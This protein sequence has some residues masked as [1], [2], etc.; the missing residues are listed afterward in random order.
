MFFKG[1][2]SRSKAALV[3]NRQVLKSIAALFGSSMTSSLLS[4]VGGFLI[5]RFIGPG[6]TGQFRAFTIPLT[7][8]TFLHLGTFDG[9]WRQIPFYIGKEQ[10]D[11]VSVLAS[12]AGAWNRLISI[13]ISCGF[14]G[15]AFFCWWHN[16]L[17]GF[18]GWLTQACV[19]WQVFYGGY[20]SATYR[21]INQFTFLARIQLIQ[22]LFNFSLV[23]ITPFLAFYGLCLRA[24]G[25]SAI[26]VWLCQRQR[27]MRM[28]LKFDKPACKELLT[29]GLPFSILGSLYTSIWVASENALI[30]ALSGTTALGLFSVAIVLREGMNMLPQTVQQ[31]FLPRVVERYS[32]TGGVHAGQKQLWLLTILITCLM[33][34]MA[35]IASYVLDIIVPI[36]IPKYIDGLP[37]FKICLWF[38]VVQ[39]A[40]LPLN[41]LFANGDYWVYGRGII[42][43]LFAF[44]VFLS[45]LY[46]LIGG[47]LS[48]ALGS[49]MG[50]AVRTILAYVE[51]YLLVNK[52]QDKV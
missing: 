18:A 47:V 25:V 49:L 40:G 31:V 2:L 42:I 9:L 10:P 20:L 28:P 48:V 27:P 46:P 35:V 21:T 29:I 43:A 11:K 45:I 50:R 51:I 15:Y 6:I 16:D 52:S 24:A 13:I 14:I 34:L 32:R 36:A 12:A 5:A 4:A 1:L 39:A 22:A 3:N 17:V 33:A 8:L 23:Y 19:T 26:G 30:L 7:F 37:L 38:S 41:S 44:L